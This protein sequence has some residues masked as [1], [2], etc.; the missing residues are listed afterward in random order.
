MNNVLTKTCIPVRV[1]SNKRICFR[2]AANIIKVAQK[3]NSSVVIYNKDKVAFSNS[4]SSIIRA[5][6]KP[7]NVVLVMATGEEPEKTISEVI[8]IMQ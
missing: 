3:Y 1:T 5:T 4:I 2:E 8:K 7:G 6:I